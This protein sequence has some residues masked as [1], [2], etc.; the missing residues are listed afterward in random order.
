MHNL[1]TLNPQKS[2]RV[3]LMY[4]AAD[5]PY[6]PRSDKDVIVELKTTSEL[7]TELKEQLQ[8]VDIGLEP[9]KQKIDAIIER[10]FEKNNLNDQIPHPII[11]N[12]EIKMGQ[13]RQ[14]LGVRPI[15]MGQLQIL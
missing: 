12:D 14:E 5:I 1:I 15:R 7:P 10:L 4:N 9:I 13:G 11:Q 2:G 8:L 3:T 6:T